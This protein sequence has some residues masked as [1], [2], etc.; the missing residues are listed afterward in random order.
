MGALL[1]GGVLVAMMAVSDTQIA[2]EPD[3]SI[4]IEISPAAGGSKTAAPE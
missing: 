1:L 4:V 2:E 3:P